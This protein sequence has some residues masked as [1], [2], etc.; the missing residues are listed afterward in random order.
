MSSFP[1]EPL[2]LPPSEGGGYYPASIHQK[3]NGNKYEIV[4]KLGYGPRSSTWLV[5]HHDPEPVYFAVQI[6]T[7]AASERAKS[8]QLPIA[9]AVDKL[10]P[11][12]R[13]PVLHGS[14]WEDSGAGAH[15]CFVTNAFGKSVGV[16]KEADNGRLPVHVV[17]RIVRSVAGA[18]EGLHGDGIMHGAITADN[19]FLALA[20]QSEFL[21]PILDSEPAPTTVKVK[22]YTTVRSQSL[23]TTC[24]W[25]DKVKAVTEWVIY[26]GNL[27]HA[28]RWNYEP[29]K[30]H[31][32]ASAPE[33]LL[34]Q[35]SCSPQT[36]IWML[37]CLTYALLTGN[38]PFY[39][40]GPPHK[41]I[42]T[43]CAVLEDEIPEAWLSDAKMKQYNA[44]AHG[45]VVS[46]DAGLADA[47]HED[48]VSAVA[49]FIKGCLRVDPEKRFKVDEC[50]THEWLAKANAC[51][52]G[53]C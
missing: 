17:Q 26:L 4:R 28:Q 52:C 31:D 37:G 38:A 35:A 8:V 42:A 53:F 41:R 43:I 50:K 29:E 10:D 7:V 51:S 36:D 16:L 45:P 6:F 34:Q 30:K 13:L 32:Y 49:A 21:K 14:F 25:N 11:F 18:L 27:G 33:T 23:T 22:K 2:D 15:L 9:K 48:D 12:L 39:S 5:L 46:I 3:L 47:L 19:V 40:T 24:K 44:D 20:T 1:E